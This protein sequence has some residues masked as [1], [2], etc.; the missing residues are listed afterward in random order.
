[1]C[2]S[3]KRHTHP[4]LAAPQSKYW[5]GYCKFSSIAQTSGRIPFCTSLSC[6]MLVF[7]SSPLHCVIAFFLFCLLAVHG[8]SSW[9]SV[10]PRGKQTLFQT[11]A[12]GQT[13]QSLVLLV[14]FP[15]WVTSITGEWVLLALVKQQGGSLSSCTG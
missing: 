8:V 5:Q 10:C 3:N 9:G 14:G 15:E 2:T 6:Y 12:G 4:F 1:M 7:N 13:F 11:E